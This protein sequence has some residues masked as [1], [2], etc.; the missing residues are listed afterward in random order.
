MALLSIVHLRIQPRIEKLFNQVK[1]DPVPQELATKIKP[2]RLLRKRLAATCLF[3]MI[4][5]VLLGLQ[6]FSRFPLLVNLLILALAGLFSARAFTKPLLL[7][8]W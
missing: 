3:L 5:T 1:G 8:W 2:L 7:G 4:A 6:V